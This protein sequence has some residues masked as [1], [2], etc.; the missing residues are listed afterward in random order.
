MNES[1]FFGISIRGWLAVLTVLTLCVMAFLGKKVEEPFYTV[2]I[3]IV[4]FY[5]GQA[6]KST[7]DK[8]NV[9]S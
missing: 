6:Q 2:V 7:G 1:K 5:F 9:P 8:N 4:S 3:S